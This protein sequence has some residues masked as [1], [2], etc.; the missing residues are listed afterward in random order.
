MG[1]EWCIRE[2][3]FN[4]YVLVGFFFL[5]KI[6]KAHSLVS[7]LVSKGGGESWKKKKKNKNKKKKITTEYLQIKTNDKSGRS[8][9]STKKLKTG[10][11]VLEEKP[12]ASVVLHNPFPDDKTLSCKF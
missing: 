9:F 1:S 10:N 6:E 3:L 12:V 2:G 8:F 5:E 7:G 4:E 11:L